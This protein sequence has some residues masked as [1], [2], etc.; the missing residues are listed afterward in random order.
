MGMRRLDVDG[1]QAIAEARRAVKEARATAK[2]LPPYSRM[3]G[4]Y[5]SNYETYRPSYDASYYD[6]SYDD[7]LP[8]SD[9]MKKILE[10]A[11]RSGKRRQASSKGSKSEA[12]IWQAYQ[13]MVK[14]YSASHADERYHSDGYRIDPYSHA[15]SG[16]YQEAMAHAYK[17]MLASYK[18][19]DR[20]AQLSFLTRLE[21]LAMA[22]YAY[23]RGSTDY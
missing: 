5:R 23:Y 19:L 11:P 7:S 8:T 21:S 1:A 22:E 10:R 15:A 17:E 16:D 12:K 14:K 4:G 20:D 18:S 3:H 6:S 9:I 13:Q 2:E